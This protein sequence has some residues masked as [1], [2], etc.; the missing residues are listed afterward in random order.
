MMY[1][2]PAC[3]GGKMISFQDS[4]EKWTK[5]SFLY[6]RYLAAGHGGVCGVVIGVRGRHA[7]AA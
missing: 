7:V 4:D 1:P 3:L 2:E 6:L 5:K